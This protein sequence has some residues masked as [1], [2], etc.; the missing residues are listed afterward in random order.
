MRRLSR[1]LA[2]DTEIWLVPT[3]V[4]LEGATASQTYD[5]VDCRIDSRDDESTAT[6]RFRL[7]E[8]Q[9]GEPPL[10]SIVRRRTESGVSTTVKLETLGAVLPVSFFSPWLQLEPTLGG[11]AKF[12]GALAVVEA[13]GRYS[14]EM[15]GLLT[16]VDLERLVAWRFP[17]HL[18]GQAAV[19]ITRARIESGRLVEAAGLL[20]SASGTIG[21]SLLVATV[22][23][24]DCRPGPTP[25]GRMPF[26]AGRNYAYNNL[27]VDFTIG[28]QGVLLESPADAEPAGALVLNEQG[29]SLVG[30]PPGGP[31]PLIQLVR[32]LVPDSELQ[33][34]ATKETARLVPWL[35]LPPVVRSPEEAPS[36]LPLRM[37]E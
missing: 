16:D 37:D 23:L 36:A 28:E 4:T 6:L 12:S 35:P 8:P 34:P 25:D 15:E 22:E 27:A 26:A 33:V 31:V 9:T 7:P 21:G 18:T 1:E 19:E 10:V 13:Q 29:R 30:A 5:D 17:H 32:A 3:Q 2:G 24:L 11:D 14:C 20:R